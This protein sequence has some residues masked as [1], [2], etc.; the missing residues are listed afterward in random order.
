VK[1]RIVP[2]EEVRADWRWRMRVVLGGL[3]MEAGVVWERER[4]WEGAVR[5][6][7]SW[8]FF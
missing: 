1:S 3:G 6:E 2:T 7:A 4:E 8:A 5:E